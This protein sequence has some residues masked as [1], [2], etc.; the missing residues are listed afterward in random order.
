LKGKESPVK[1]SRNW[2]YQAYSEVSPTMMV[3]PVLLENARNVGPRLQETDVEVLGLEGT[4]V[5]KLKTASIYTVDQLANSDETT[6]LHIPHFGIG[7]VNRIRACLNSY[8]TAVL[9]GRPPENPGELQ[10]LDVRKSSKQH[11]KSPQRSSTVRSR[12]AIESLSERIRN[13]EK[14]IESLESKADGLENPS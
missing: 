10:G 1:L 2:K 12:L 9:Q 14:R 8:L 5:N 6:L 3:N 11:K 13:L 4:S 7:K